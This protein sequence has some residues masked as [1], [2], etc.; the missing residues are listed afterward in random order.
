LDTHASSRRVYQESLEGLGLAT[1]A[2]AREEEMFAQLNRDAVA[3]DLPQL[4]VISAGP[5][6]SDSIA[7]LEAIQ[8]DDE[9]SRLPR[10]LLFPPGRAEECGVDL[11]GTLCITKPVK[12][13]QLAE[14][15]AQLLDA[16]RVNSASTSDAGPPP[17][18]PLRILLAED[19]DVNQEYAAGLLELQGHNVQIAN[20]GKEALEALSFEQFDVVLMDCE[21]PEMDG[22]ETTA[23][24]RAGE[25][26]S[27]MHIPIIAMTAHAAEEF[28]QRCLEAGMDDYITKPI[29]PTRLIEMLARIVS[30][31]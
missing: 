31:S 30:Y 14:A 12:P 7:L 28:R 8:Q 10:L 19:G 2:C 4:L 15:V 24:I 21:M 18:R 26:D 25:A 13:S 29:E 23:A 11:Q 27:G 22:L 5:R 16:K 17:L 1:T 6:E 9:L 20:N 3:G